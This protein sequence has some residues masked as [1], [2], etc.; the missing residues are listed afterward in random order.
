MKIE[1]V[2]KFIEDNKDKLPLSYNNLM[3]KTNEE[4]EKTG[5]SINSEKFKDGNY[6][7]FKFY[8]PISRLK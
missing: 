4:I 2:K 6:S 7:I 5:K 8:K 1:K 3:Y